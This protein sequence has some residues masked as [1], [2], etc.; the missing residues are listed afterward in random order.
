[1]SDQ[2]IILILMTFGAVLLAIVFSLRVLIVLERKIARIEM[3]IESLVK[4]VLEEE[5][6]IEKEQEKIE[7]ALH[8][9][10]FPKKNSKKKK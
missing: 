7:D 5:Q 8:I 4:S 1:M 6:I 2:I 3:H 10:S 9:N